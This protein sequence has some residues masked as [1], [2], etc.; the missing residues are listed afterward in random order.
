MGA[1]DKKRVKM[2]EMEIKMKKLQAENES[3]L[4][5]RQMPLTPPPEGPVSPSSSISDHSLVDSRSFESAEESGSEVGRGSPASVD[6]YDDDN[7]T[8][9]VLSGGFGSSQV[10]TALDDIAKLLEGVDS[11]STIKEETSGESHDCRET[12]DLM[13]WFKQDDE[14]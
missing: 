11:D 1:R 4:N 13:S 2:D 3:L 6:S 8:G 12:A 9:S 14:V 10:Q 7:G 5:G